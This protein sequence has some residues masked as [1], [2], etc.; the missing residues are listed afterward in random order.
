MLYNPYRYFIIPSDNQYHI[1]HIDGKYSIKNKK[2]L[3]KDVFNKLAE[4]KKY[5]LTYK[6]KSYLIYY[7]SEFK[8]RYLLLKIGRE[9]NR[10]IHR[11]AEEDID[12]VQILDYPY[13]YIIV[14]QEKQILLIEHSTQVFK[15][16]EICT[17]I[18]QHFFQKFASEYFYEIIMNPMLIEDKF[19]EAINTFDSLSELE[20]KL[21]SPN[22][23]EGIKITTEF[24]NKIKEKYNNTETKIKLKNTQNS[25]T[26]SRDNEELESAI[27][28][29]R[30]GGGEWTITGK[31]DSK[32]DI[33]K[34]IEHL[35]LITCED[36]IQLAFENNSSV[37]STIFSKVK[38]D[39]NE[40]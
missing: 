5:R 9:K 16:T 12:D 23:F 24:L 35:Q 14:D 19:W 22:L 38:D 34:S 28:Y 15:S 4:I 33:A 21:E 6:S 10:E 36:D 3:I 11:E 2:Q 13:V 26:I 31:I 39:F 18:I 7:I 37:I 29:I 27:K 40:N 1:N 30:N 32:K 20:I 8:E 25:L 17:R